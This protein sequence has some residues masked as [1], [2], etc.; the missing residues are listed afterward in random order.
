MI[1]TAY[2]TGSSSSPVSVPCFTNLTRPA[3]AFA[4]VDGG[5]FRLRNPLATLLL[6]GQSLLLDLVAVFVQQGDRLAMVDV[7]VEDE[8]ATQA[9][10]LDRFG[11]GF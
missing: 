5:L 10:P 6:L 2:R 11:D 4:A 9:A 7:D 1:M 3:R 8:F